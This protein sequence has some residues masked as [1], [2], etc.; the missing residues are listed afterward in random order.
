MF[1]PYDSRDMMPA[2]GRYGGDPAMEG[3]PGGMM[4]HSGGP[5][6]GMHHHMMGG[7]PGPMRGGGG[8]KTLLDTPPVPPLSSPTN[9]D[10]YDGPGGYPPPRGPSQRDGYRGDVDDQYTP[11]SHHEP[12]PPSRETYGGHPPSRGGHSASE[13]CCCTL[14][15]VSRY[16]THT[17]APQ[18]RCASDKVT[19]AAYA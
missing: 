4:P 8:R 15:T 17:H 14:L 1:D 6:D 7:P 13:Y 5:G 11:A 12:Y 3:G 9:N 2:H 10:G 18:M 19:L 16:L